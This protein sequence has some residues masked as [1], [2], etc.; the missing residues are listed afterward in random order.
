MI[1]II[2]A[3]RLSHDGF[4]TEAPLG[5]SLKRLAFDKRI[6]GRVAFENRAGLPSI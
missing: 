3:T 4:L 1:N 5:T 2:S 6:R